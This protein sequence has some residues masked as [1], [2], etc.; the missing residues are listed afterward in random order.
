MWVSWLERLV[1]ACWWVELGLV[2]LGWAVSKMCLRGGCR[3]KKTFGNF[4]VDGWVCVSSLLVIWPEASQPWSQRLLGGARSWCLQ[5]SSHQFAGTSATFPGGSDGKASVSNAGD[6]GSIPGSGRFPG[7]GN[8][9]PLQY[10]CLENPMDGGAWCRL[11]PTGL[12]RVRPDWATSLSLPPGFL[13]PQWARA[14]PTPTY[15][16]LP[17]Q[18]TLQDKQVGLA[19]APAKSPSSWVLVCMKPCVPPPYWSFCFR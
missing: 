5:E 1:P 19:Q 9:N 15:T 8:S 17:L 16:H 3:L 2:L 6:L 10:S 7:E 14:L 18:H 13:S 11:L 4:S 12:Q